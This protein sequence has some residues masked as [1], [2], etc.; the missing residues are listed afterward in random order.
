MSIF[1]SRHQN[2]VATPAMPAERSRAAREKSRDQLRDPL[3]SVLMS[4]MR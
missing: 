3:T 2:R 1:K 4:A